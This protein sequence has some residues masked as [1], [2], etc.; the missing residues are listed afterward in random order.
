MIEKEFEQADR[1]TILAA[2]RQAK[3]VFREVRSSALQQAT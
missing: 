1:Q 3:D 2:T